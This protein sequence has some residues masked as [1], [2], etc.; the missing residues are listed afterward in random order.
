MMEEDLRS[1]VVKY[2]KNLSEDATIIVCK[3]SD[4]IPAIFKLTGEKITAGKNLLIYLRNKLGWVV[5]VWMVALTI[6]PEWTPT[7]PD[8]VNF[9]VDRGPEL[10]AQLDFSFPYDPPSGIHWVQFRGVDS[11]GQP[12]PDSTITIPATGFDPRLLG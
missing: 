7:L 4:D 12:N 5:A 6:A 8:I 3:K 9:A 1:E 11:T 2:I 10:M